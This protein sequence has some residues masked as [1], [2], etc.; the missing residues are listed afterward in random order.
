[1]KKYL[2]IFLLASCTQKQPEPV[3]MNAV[4]TTT[5]SLTTFNTTV[6]ALKSQF[7]NQQAQIDSLKKVV[8][9][10]NT[11]IQM[12]VKNDESIFKDISEM[13]KRTDEL[14]KHNWYQDSLLN[15]NYNT[16]YDPLYF[17]VNKLSENNYFITKP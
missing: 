5:V 1:M 3:A 11:T 6:S 12:L 8:A 15:I 13:Y 10:Q 16:T 2:T 14:Q 4:L 7:Q 9:S 17:K